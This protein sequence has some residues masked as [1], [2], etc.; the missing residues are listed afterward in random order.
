[1]ATID[2]ESLKTAQFFDD[3]TGKMVSIEL[4]VRDIVLFKLLERLCNK[5]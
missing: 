2:G 4:K 1:M 5:Q 3:E